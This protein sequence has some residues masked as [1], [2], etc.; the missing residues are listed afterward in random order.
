MTDTDADN[1][2]AEILNV[3]LFDGVNEISFD[4]GLKTGKI[5]YIEDSFYDKYLDCLEAQSVN[6]GVCA[7]SG[8]KVVY[9]PLNG[10]GNKLVRKI[11]ARVGVKE[12][13]VVPEQEL[14]DGSFPHLPLSEPGISGGSHPGP[15][16]GPGKQAGPGSGHRPRQR[17]GG[18]RREGR[19]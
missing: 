6:P 13:Q 4:E 7:D 1:V 18:H 14:P 19:R 15:E 12:I 3:D 8:L 16:D 5:V 11:L 10:A 9:T 17:P 2:Y